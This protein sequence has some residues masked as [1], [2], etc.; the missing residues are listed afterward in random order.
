[1]IDI[2]V[3]DDDE[4]DQERYKAFLSSYRLIFRQRGDEALAALADTPSIALAIVLWEL[5]GTPSGPEVV[6]RIC[7][8]KLPI[9][10]IVTSGLLDLSRAGRAKSMGA[11]DFLLKP[12]DR[13]RLRSSATKALGSQEDP[14]LLRALRARLI[15][16]SSA[17]NE[18]LASLARV[19]PHDDKTVLLVG[20]N[21]TGKELLARAVHELGKRCGRP[22]LPIN[23]ASIPPSL[24]ESTLFGH[25]KGAFTN[26]HE[27]Q[28]GAFE[29]CR[30]GVLFLDEIGEL[31][32]NLQT[33]LLRVLQERTFRRIGGKEDLTFSARLVCATN[34]DLVGDM[35]KGRFREDFYFR[36]SGY[37]VRVP[38][39][40]ERGN[41]LRLLIYHFIQEFGGGRRLSLAKETWKLIAGYSFPGNVRELRD[42]IGYAV[43]ECQDEEILPYHL[44]LSIMAE[45][46]D[47]TSQETLRPRWPAH[48]FRLPQKEAM[49][50]IEKAFDREYLPRV[51]DEA[52]G[53]VTRAAAAAALDQKTFRKKWKE[54]DLPEM[55][56][57][58][59]PTPSE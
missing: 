43:V 25:E 17:L 19:I 30:A 36:I 47:T 27:R 22:W 57:R 15:G 53:N 7:H 46:A 59:L 24:I 58:N 56:H 12:L 45:R 51:L 33:K 32:P 4:R 14:P 52:S 41:D 35:K 1:M 6:M 50:E 55:S 21:G 26:A 13:E 48:L 5:P 2:L 3:V 49:E 40:R 39:L 9:P 44:P 54:A 38:P 16:E 8:G 28:V 29:E 23:V 18:A 11:C 42:I 10:V 20:E 31:E 37:E 34:R